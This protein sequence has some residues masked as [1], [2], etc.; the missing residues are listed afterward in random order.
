MPKEVAQKHLL[1]LGLEHAFITEE[2]IRT[3][4][5]RSLTDIL[6]AEEERSYRATLGE[7][8]I[9]AEEGGYVAIADKG[10]AA[11]SKLPPQKRHAVLAIRYAKYWLSWRE[12]D[13]ST[14]EGDHSSLPIETNQENR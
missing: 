12:K 1:L 7:E 8:D 3:A 5:T 4:I 9:L 13:K 6:T 2:Q 10:L 14:R 11:L